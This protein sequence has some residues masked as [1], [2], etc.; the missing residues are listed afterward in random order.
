MEIGFNLIKETFTSKVTLVEAAKV[1]SEAVSGPFRKMNNI[2][3]IDYISDKECEINLIIEF[4]F[5]SFILQNIIGQL[6]ES[7]SKK[8]ITAF[9]ER[10]N[11]LYK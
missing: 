3:E 8:M 11:Y 10:A 7:A 6:F 4:E 2:W 1:H 5:K 9:E